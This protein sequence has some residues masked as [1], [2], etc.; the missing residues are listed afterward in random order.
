MIYIVHRGLLN[1]PS[2]WE[3][4]PWVLEEAIAEC[5]NAE[6]D[7]WL[8]EDGKFALGHDAPKHII[9][10]K[11]LWENQVGLWIHCKNIPALEFFNREGIFY[12]YFWHEEDT[13]TLTSKNYI[14]AYPGKQPIAG[15]IAVL[16]ERFDDDISVC[17]GVCTDYVLRYRGDL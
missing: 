10:E 8:T 4:A 1:G 2:E 13:V 5:G 7:L 12:H 17:D 15:S 16:P 3:N 9:N 6:C 14:W 11:W